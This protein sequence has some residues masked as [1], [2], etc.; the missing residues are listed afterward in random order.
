MTCYMPCDLF[1][2]TEIYKTAVQHSYR[3]IFIKQTTIF[4]DLTMIT[5]TLYTKS[6][7]QMQQNNAQD[8]TKT[9]SLYNPQ[10][11]LQTY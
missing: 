8:S 9:E 3:T 7:T 5:F 11:P 2:T 4:Y 10:N 6:K 1:Y